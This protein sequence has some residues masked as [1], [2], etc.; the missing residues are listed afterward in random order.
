MINNFSELSLFKARNNTFRLQRRIFKS[1]LIG[2]LVS[3]FRIQKI[4]ISSNSSR[5][6]AIRYIT[7]NRSNLVF[8][9]L[10]K[11]SLSLIDKFKLNQYLIDNVYN[12]KPQK[13]S[14]F[15]TFKTRTAYPYPFEL[16][17][18][19]D[20][21]WQS[22]VKFA[23]EPAQEAIFSPRSFGFR[24]TPLFYEMQKLIFLNLGI[25][26]FGSQ[27]RVLILSFKEIIELFDYGKFFKKLLVPRFVKIG[28]FRFLKLGF[29]FRFQN[30][31]KDFYFLNSLLANVLLNGIDIVF[32][33][34]RFGAIMI[35]FLRP[36]DNEILF[37]NKIRS[38]LVF[39]GIDKV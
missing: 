1:V 22:L 11:S 17:S 30:D 26:S 35:T 14:N 4:L 15:S 23:L 39:T 13:L 8:S 16:W 29:K 6:L 34:G 27:K 31:F 7:Q 25:S 24:S 33:S 38:F 10:E 37:L 32:N 20:Y 21:C 12:W 36:L 9:F 28:I 19:F 2:D 5:F 3:A 18:K